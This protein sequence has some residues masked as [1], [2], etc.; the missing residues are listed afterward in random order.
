MHN[1]SVDGWMDG[2]GVVVCSLLCGSFVR[3]LMCGGALEES[4]I[5]VSSV[6]PS[7]FD[8][9]LFS[10]VLLFHSSLSTGELCFG[11]HQEELSEADSE[12]K[13]SRQESFV[14]TT[15]GSDSRYSGQS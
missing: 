3:L 13:G 11:L 1:E 15:A 4:W 9:D 5:D 10:A 14:T 12:T 2:S 8:S 7:V 6:P